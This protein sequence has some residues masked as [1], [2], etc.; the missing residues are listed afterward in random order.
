MSGQ[1]PLGLNLRNLFYLDLGRNSFEGTIP[2]DWYEGSNNMA[3][4]RHLHLDYNI[5]SGEL[6]YNF[7]RLGSSR[8]DQIV[9]NDNQFSG[10]FP[11]GWDPLTALEVLRIHNNQF[12]SVSKDL[13]IMSVFVGGEVTDL[14]TDCAACGCND[15][16]CRSPYCV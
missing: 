4:L 3:S 14:R 13:C 7:P 10:E 6:N 9:L 12:W 1:I 16:W 15:I 11:G 2:I 8:M 5:F